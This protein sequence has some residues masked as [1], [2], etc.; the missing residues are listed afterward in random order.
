MTYNTVAQRRNEVHVN[1]QIRFLLN[2]GN[3]IAPYCLGWI[4]SGLI[5][6]ELIWPNLWISR[7]AVQ[8]TAAV[9]VLRL[10]QWRQWRSNDAKRVNG[11]GME[12]VKREGSFFRPAFFL[13]GK[14]DDDV[15]FRLYAILTYLNYD[16]PA[17]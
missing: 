9:T 12:E 5:T 4:S 6:M 7:S 14:E 2:K 16:N 1:I 8:N 3:Q 17:E 10:R 11:C 13:L 15:L